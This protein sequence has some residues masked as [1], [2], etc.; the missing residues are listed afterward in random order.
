MHFEDKFKAVYI[1]L[2]VIDDFM[3]DEPFCELSIQDENGMILEQYS[4]QCNFDNP[5]GIIIWANK[6]LEQKDFVNSIGIF[7]SCWQGWKQE[8]FFWENH[9]DI[10]Y[11]R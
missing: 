1:D 4:A 5:Q 3:L 7:E 9:A 6:I 10:L 11:Q 2:K 8:D